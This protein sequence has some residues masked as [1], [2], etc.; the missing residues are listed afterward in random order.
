[1]PLHD[2]VAKTLPI[3]SVMYETEHTANGQQIHIWVEPAVADKLAAMR[4]PSESYSDVI[5]G[6]EAV[7]HESRRASLGPSSISPSSTVLCFR[8]RA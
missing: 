2:A 7:G 1:M 5:L 4:G 8:R 3:G 6:L